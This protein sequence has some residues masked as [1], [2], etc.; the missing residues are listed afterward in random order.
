MKVSESAVIKVKT[1]AVCDSPVER[2]FQRNV[3]QVLETDRSAP[4]PTMLEHGP[5]D[6][7]VEPIA[8]SRYYSPAFFEL[9]RERLWPKVWQFACWTHDIPEAGDVYVYR[10]L[11]K[12]IL[13]AR[14]RDGSVK[15]FLNACLHRGRELCDK[16]DHVRQFKC[17]YHHFT[18]A[19]DG[20]LTVVPSAWDFP[21]FKVG[22]QSLPEVRVDEWNGFIFVNFDPDAAPLKE[23]LGDRF[24][25]QW[26]G[27]DFVGTR[28]K[29]V[30]VA[31]RMRVNWKTARDAFM[32]GYHGPAVHVGSD[33]LTLGNKDPG[34]ATQV[35][36]F[37][38][39][40]H[41][42]RFHM[43]MG[44]QVPGVEKADPSPE[45]AVTYFCS[46]LLPDQTEIEG[47]ILEGETFRDA[48]ARIARKAH[49]LRMG[50][51]TSQ[52]SNAEALDAIEYAV[53]PNFMVWQGLMW[54]LVYRFRPLGPEEC[55]WETMLL[56]PFEG[57]R[58]PSA[59]V[60]NLGPEQSWNEAQELGVLALILSQDDEN[61]EPTQRGLHNLS[62][63]MIQ[64]SAYQEAQIRHFNRALSQYLHT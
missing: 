2:S 51:D 26:A 25:T 21:Q 59:K 41:T 9:E 17:P 61:M 53:F 52:V 12:S 43:A 60:R 42:S 19:L 5:T 55:V 10:I 1:D 57:E 45:E 8:A 14:Q 7:G 16:D 23:F 39:S 13:V 49:A 24:L 40:P 4:A 63:G 50:V 31:K 34:A 33:N 30:H 37:P 58:P 6:V 11:E 56:L 32:E 38:D 18:Y 44:V 48:C 54:P 20:R 3:R 64:P 29:A 15:A 27:Q 46:F 62:T 22:E 35:D 28:Y 36:V 47:K